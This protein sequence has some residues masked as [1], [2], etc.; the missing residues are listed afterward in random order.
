MPIIF[1]SQ[2]LK[3]P[4]CNES[5]AGPA[6]QPTKRKKYSAAE[7]NNC[8]R[9]KT[10]QILRMCDFFFELS[11]HDTYK[12]PQSKMVGS[13]KQ[14]TCSYNGQ[15][16]KHFLFEVRKEKIVRVVMP[17]QLPDICIL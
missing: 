15:F 2:F 8:M 3:A 16:G 14:T 12:S 1:L 11:K 13:V 5:K 7:R 17:P 10:L 4:K 6:C 9:K